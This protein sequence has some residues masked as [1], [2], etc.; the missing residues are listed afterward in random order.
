VHEAVLRIFFFGFSLAAANSGA[1]WK[2]AT[3]A[4]DTFD[5]AEESWLRGEDLNL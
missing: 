4:A 2:K 1:A 3:R 5:F